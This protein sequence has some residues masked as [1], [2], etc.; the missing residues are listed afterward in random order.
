MSS[1]D[2]DVGQDGS[3]TLVLLSASLSRARSLMELAG[4]ELRLAAVSGLSM[5]LL[6]LL[7]GGALMISWGL[8]V[9]SCL[10]IAATLGIPWVWTALVLALAHALLAVYLW[11]AAVGLSRDLTLPELRKSLVASTTEREVRHD[12]R[13]SSNGA[14]RQTPT[15]AGSS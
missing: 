8:L 12:A 13:R 9:V 14:R 7:A 6:I 2:H 4:A 5:L 11:H 1:T 15:P 10:Q 3:R